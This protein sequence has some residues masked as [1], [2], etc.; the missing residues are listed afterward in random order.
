MRGVPREAEGMEA[1]MGERILSLRDETGNRTGREYS[2]SGYIA[3]ETRKGRGGIWAR[4]GE[5]YDFAGEL[6]DVGNRAA[7][8]SWEVVTHT[9]HSCH[10]T[11]QE[12]KCLC[13]PVNH[14][15][16]TH[17]RFV[18]SRNRVDGWCG[19]EFDAALG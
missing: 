15:K 10:N 18:R 8:L 4:N 7:G 11:Y 5:S 14:Q 17:P 6:G 9:W 12:T 13:Y 16:C 3:D 19:L 1:D 2:C